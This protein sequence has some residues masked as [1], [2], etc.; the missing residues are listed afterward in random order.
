MGNF[1][2]VMSVQASNELVGCKV[3]AWSGCHEGES[4]RFG[5]IVEFV[6]HSKFGLYNIVQFSDGTRETALRFK[7]PTDN[8]IG[9]YLEVH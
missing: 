6:G 5:E 1:N 8:G 7:L 3:R 2:T 4:E 9:I